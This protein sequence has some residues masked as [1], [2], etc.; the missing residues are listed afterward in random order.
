MYK[1]EVNL[2]ES[3]VSRISHSELQELIKAGAVQ[4]KG[5]DYKVDFIFEAWSGDWLT[6]YRLQF[7]PANMRGHYVD[8]DFSYNGWFTVR[9]KVWNPSKGSW[10]E[11]DLPIGRLEK[12]AH[13]IEN[14]DRIGHD[15]YT[16][17]EAN[18]YT[19]NVLINDYPK[20]NLI[21]K[22]ISCTP[23]SKYKKRV[24]IR[25]EVMELDKRVR[26]LMKIL[27]GKVKIFY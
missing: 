4:V 18:D 26:A 2:T 9:G 22:L 25:K 3:D 21:G 19:L 16:N 1:I 6:R 15:S 17:L 10:K 5:R 7:W 24:N 20:N 13:L 8:I 23:P 14:S 12:L 27:D 11:G